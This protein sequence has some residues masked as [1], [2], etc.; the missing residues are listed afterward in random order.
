MNRSVP[1]PDS[2]IRFVGYQE[3]LAGDYRVTRVCVCSICA[4]SFPRI[5]SCPS[6]P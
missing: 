1:A 2:I 5:D 6:C 4:E 3:E